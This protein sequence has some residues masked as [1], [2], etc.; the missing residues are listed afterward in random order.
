MIT[1]GGI[2]SRQL[3]ANLLAPYIAAAAQSVLDAAPQSEAYERA[4]S[5]A[6]AQLVAEKAAMEGEVEPTLVSSAA[7]SSPSLK[8]RKFASVVLAASGYSDA[9]NAKPSEIHQSRIE[10]LARTI[11][12]LDALQEH[13]EAAA[14]RLVEIFDRAVDKLAGRLDLVDI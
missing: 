8:T 10:Q 5:E 9:E 4:V 14:A 3:P 7:L 11:A 13:D 12:L 2:A 1:S 6:R